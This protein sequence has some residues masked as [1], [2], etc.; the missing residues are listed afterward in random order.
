MY[1]MFRP[2]RSSSGNNFKRNMT[3]FLKIFFCFYFCADLF[4]ILSN[5]SHCDIIYEGIYSSVTTQLFSY[6]LFICNVYLYLNF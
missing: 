5:T 2:Q 6:I 3:V 4:K 1:N